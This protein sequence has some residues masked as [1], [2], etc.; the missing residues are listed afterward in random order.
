MMPRD[1]SYTHEGASSWGWST[2]RK[3]AKK[4]RLTVSS[5]LTPTTELLLTPGFATTLDGEI[6]SREALELEVLAWRQDMLT[7]TRQ[8]PARHP[9]VAYELRVTMPGASRRMQIQCFP[10]WEGSV[11]DYVPVTFFLCPVCLAVYRLR[12]VEIVVPSVTEVVMPVDVVAVAQS[13][14]RVTTQSSKEPASA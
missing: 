10:N 5:R 3:L 14:A 1:E 12:E 9:V 13:D 8:C 11:K 7:G 4:L 2:F 6:R